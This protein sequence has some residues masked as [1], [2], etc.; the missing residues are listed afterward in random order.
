MDALNILIG[1][2]AFEHVPAEHMVEVGRSGQKRLFMA[3]SVLMTEGDAS[4]NLYFLV[5]GKVVVEIGVG[6]PKSQLLAE[7]G[8]GEFV[9]EMGVLRQKPRSATV[10]ALSDLETLELTLAQVKEI[11]RHDHE[12][13]L[14]FFRIIHQRQLARTD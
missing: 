8:P 5:R 10:T 9:G 4:D 3:N 2:P 12:M 14:G 11:F 7:L 6:G 1:N 13:L